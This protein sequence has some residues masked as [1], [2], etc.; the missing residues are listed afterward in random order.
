VGEVEVI[1]FLAL[2]RRPLDRPAF[3]RDLIPPRSLARRE[4]GENRPEFA[5]LSCG[6]FGNPGNTAE[7]GDFPKRGNP[8]ISI[9]SQ[10]QP[11]G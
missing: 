11:F 3:D 8:F 7:F 1:G 6:W 5:R 10:N 4:P 2:V 9:L